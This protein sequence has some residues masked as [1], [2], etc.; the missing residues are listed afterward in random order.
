M[1]DCLASPTRRKWLFGML[2][3]SEGI[4]PIGFIWLGLPTRLR[5]VDVPLDRITWLSVLLILPW[6]LKFLWASLIHLLRG[7]R[8]GFKHWI[9]ISQTAM[10]LSLLPLIWLTFQLS[11]CWFRCGRRCMPSPRRHKMFLSMRRA[12]RSRR[13]GSEVL[14][15]AGCNAACSLGGQPWGAACSSWN[16]GLGSQESS[17]YLSDWYSAP[18]R[19]LLV[20]AREQALSAVSAAAVEGVG[21]S[22]VLRR[23]REMFAELL[24]AVRSRG[25]WVGLLF[26]MTAPAAFKSLEAVIG[27]FLIDHGYSQLQVGQFTATMMIGRMI[28]GS[29]FAGRVSHLYSGPRF[30]MLG[31]AANLFAIGLLAAVDYLLGGRQGLHLFAILVVVAFSIGW[32]T[33]AL[34]HWLMNLTSPCWPRPSSLHLWP[35]PTSA[36]HGR[37]LCSESFR[38]RWAIPSQC[39]Y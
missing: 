10:A 17:W 19:S 16:T 25:I 31:L 37:R 8:W 36:R 18:R 4:A 2:Y 13:P 35:P 21:E 6:T 14:S 28:L 32:F 20:F 23:M 15:M 39:C 27:P 33:V 3:L 26:A 12:F 1:L 24:Q 5:A 11:S 29:L 30:V 7:P 34:Y 22:L 9:L 38:C